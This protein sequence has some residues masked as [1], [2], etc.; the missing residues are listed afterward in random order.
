[1]TCMFDLIAG[2]CDHQRIS[3]LEALEKIHRTE[4]LLEERQREAAER[5]VQARADLA[6]HVLS[7]SRVAR[8]RGSYDANVGIGNDEYSAT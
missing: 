8:H 4:A 6:D 1:M 5:A 7:A 2:R 3:D